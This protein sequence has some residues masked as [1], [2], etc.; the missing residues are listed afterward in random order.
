MDVRGGPHR[1]R[2]AVV[3]EPTGALRPAL[4]FMTCTTEAEQAVCLKKKNFKAVQ[5]GGWVEVAFEY[6]PFI[7]VM[8]IH[9]RIKGLLLYKDRFHKNALIFLNSCSIQML[10]YG[11]Q[12]IKNRTA[13]I[14]LNHFKT[15]LIEMT[16]KGK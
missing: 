6:S 2:P 4:R 9:C 12:T 8:F 11:G 13:V 14:L 10:G 5:S 15:V 7:H 1:P 3:H 16:A